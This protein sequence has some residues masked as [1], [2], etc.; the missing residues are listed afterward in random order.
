MTVFAEKLGALAATIE[1]ALDGPLALLAEAL[2]VGI[3]RTVVA[4]GSGGS[5]VAA[6]YLARC[7][8]TLGLGATIVRTPMDL[9]LGDAVAA[10][11]TWLLSAGAE[12]PDIAA[13]FRA[14]VDAGAGPI[15]ML[16]S[17]ATGAVA[18]EVGR[19]PRG[20]TFV[21]PVADPKDGFL[22]THS[23]VA[24]IA[25]LLMAADL[26]AEQPAPDAVLGRFVE[27]CGAALDN[28]GRIVSDFRKGDTVVLLHDPQVRA[29]ATLI[30]TSLWET[31]I[32]PVQK[33]DF[34]NF[35]HGR[36]VWAARHPETMLVLALTTAETGKTWDAIAAALPPQVRRASYDIGHAGRGKVAAGVVAGLA[37][38]RALGD[39]AGIDPGRPGIGEFARPIYEDASL[40]G[41]AEALTPPVRHKRRAM[42]AHDAA[43][44]MHP[45]ICA[46][47]RERI[48][49][50]GAA[51]FGGLVLDY[52]GTLVATA[53]RFD[54]PAPEIVAE[55][56]RLA[57]QGVR[58]GIATGRGGSAGEMLR[59]S[60]PIRVHP[61]LLVGYYNGGHLRRLDVDIRDDA[62]EPDPAIASVSE[63][64]R[65]S[66]L[67]LPSV[68]WRQ[69]PVQITIE[70]AQLRDARGFARALEDCPAVAAGLVRILSSH[71]S[72]DVVPTAS[73]K[74]AV[75]RALRRT[76]DEPVLCVGDSGSPRGNDYEL[77]SEPHGTS[78]DAVCGSAAGCWS[79]FGE[80]PKGPD[81]VLRLLRSLRAADGGV[82][83]DLGALKFD[84]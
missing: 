27:D 79:L 30:E 22:A 70:H 73:S 43:A 71:H 83:V 17:R 40:L 3:G 20:S 1:L 63:W 7:R 80:Y 45:S 60:L 54:P 62:P 39:S 10:D 36:H 76:A 65:V 6:E 69:A 34:R 19:H 52:D 29:V 56:T 26:C 50:L 77:L 66:G 37:M 13:A 15:R 84:A 68:E 35:A 2:K 4:V 18:V 32:A 12:N 21:L 41:L 38:V 75:V 61:L 16:T 64:L 59:S 74:L 55:L 23:L 31:G 33:V 53:H 42:L 57:D 9:V 5:A 78:V 25:A 28:D 11:E 51:R 48:R 47:G 81:A 49:D 58:M 44:G 72:V 8:A 67:L 24:T 14:A 82:V 46:V